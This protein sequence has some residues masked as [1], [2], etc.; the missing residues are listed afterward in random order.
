MHMKSERWVS[1]W[2]PLC[3]WLLE[4][5]K[6]L[7]RDPQTAFMLRESIYHSWIVSQDHLLSEDDCSIRWKECEVWFISWL[8]QI[9]RLRSWSVRGWLLQTPKSGGSID[10]R[11]LSFSEVP[12]FIH[13]LCS[14][15]GLSRHLWCREECRGKT[16]QPSSEC[17]TKGNRT[18]KSFE[19]CWCSICDGW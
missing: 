13:Q 1:H 4:S 15:Q 5:V 19:K 16:P 11:E 10:E 9:S 17:S 2:S 7:I 12:W 14:G 6:L 3:A 8:L 18:A